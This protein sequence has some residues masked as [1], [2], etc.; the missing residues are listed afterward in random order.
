[1][2]RTGGR[3]HSSDI[4]RI[5]NVSGIEAVNQTEPE[6]P[7]PS[8]KKEDSTAST[9]SF[10]WLLSEHEIDFGRRKRIHENRNNSNSKDEALKSDCDD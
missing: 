9:H 1:M 3:I 10:S 8:E 4:R 2:P 6:K 5:G 7:T